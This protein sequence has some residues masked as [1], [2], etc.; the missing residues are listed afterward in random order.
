MPPRAPNTNA[1]W[2]TADETVLLE[3]LKLNAAAAGDG[4]SFKAPTFLSASVAVNAIRTKGGPKTA[5]ACKN[6]FSAVRVHQ[7]RE[8]RR[9]ILLYLSAREFSN[10]RR[11][12]NNFLEA[13]LAVRQQ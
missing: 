7:S 13:S 11:L 3:H 1:Y 4:A 5:S 12:C 2:T 8:M 9:E 10:A 6:K